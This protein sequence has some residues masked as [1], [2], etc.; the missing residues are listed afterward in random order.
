LSD[1]PKR[2]WNWPDNPE[3]IRE[4]DDEALLKLWRYAPKAEN[5]HQI[6]CSKILCDE[7]VDRNL[8]N[9]IKR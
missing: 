3:V 6:K 8:E 1:L 9:R 2:K 4:L 7:I 5:E